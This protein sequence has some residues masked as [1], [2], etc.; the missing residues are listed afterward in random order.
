M[1]NP[2]IYILILILLTATV[3]AEFD[4]SRDEL[5]EFSLYDTGNRNEISTGNAYFTSENFPSPNCIATGFLLDYQPKVIMVN[6]ER[7]IVLQGIDNSVP[8]LQIFDTS[9]NIVGDVSGYVGDAHN[10]E[11]LFFDNGNNYTF[12]YPD[13]KNN[14][15]RFDFNGTDIIQG[16]TYYLGNLTNSLGSCQYMAYSDDNECYW[17]NVTNDIE[18]VNLD[19]GVT[20]DWDVIEATA[21]D[22][23]TRKPA[24]G[25]PLTV[26]AERLLVYGK[27][28]ATHLFLCE[29]DPSVGGISSTF[30][31]GACQTVSGSSADYVPPVMYNIDVFGASEYT[32]GYTHGSAYGVVSY[33]NLGVIKYIS[34]S[35]T[36]TKEIISNLFIFRNDTG[37]AGICTVRNIASNGFEVPLCVGVPFISKTPT[38]VEDYFDMD[39]TGYQITSGDFIADR[40]GDE[41]MSGYGV[42]DILIGTTG[43][44]ITRI[45]NPEVFNGT[46]SV[47]DIDDNGYLDIVYQNASDTYIA[48]TPD[49]NE[50]PYWTAS[51]DLFT[52]V[53]ENTLLC[54]DTTYGILS[55]TSYYDDNLDQV[56]MNV[57]CF[58]DGTQVAESVSA[59]GGA[60]TQMT[61]ECLFNKTG[62][63]VMRVWIE[64]DKGAV[65]TNATLAYTVT[66]DT[67]ICA[68]P[69]TAGDVTGGTVGGNVTVDTPAED[70]EDL[71][72]PFGLTGSWLTAV[73]VFVMIFVSIA[74]I[75][76]LSSAGAGSAMLPSLAIVNV[77]MLVLGW[78]FGMI[79]TVI[80][81]IVAIVAVLFIVLL[82]FRGGE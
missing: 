5:Y 76:M 75:Q 74:V 35:A 8:T 50:A 33:T 16:P 26:T 53:A 63:F 3:T 80:I 60:P 29:V 73:W 11:A 27:K 2:I 9:C 22:T 28:N 62:T 49:L 44:N 42:Y 34:F 36:S 54:N 23:S 20:I 32:V 18:G 47:A 82:L 24:V 69:S 37:H 81:S 61:A 56:T 15:T 59:S 41:I 70:A 21:Y 1:K 30:N 64:D 43:Y 38:A 66:D 13:V 57:D 65:S 79:S 31:G 78:I 6:D 48:I 19:T 25:S 77:L 7:F 45:E 46:F 67:E 68:A 72:S 17:Q 52:L 71:F 4:R 12:L 40:I 39:A 55:S 58:G 10:A 14:V 51:T